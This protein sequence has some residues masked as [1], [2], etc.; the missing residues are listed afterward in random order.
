MTGYLPDSF[1]NGVRLDISRDKLAYHA[2]SHDAFS[3]RHTEEDLIPYLK[4]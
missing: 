2:K 4:P 3:W 1:N